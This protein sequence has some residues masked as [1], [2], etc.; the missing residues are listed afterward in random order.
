M[1]RQR[2]IEGG[3]RIILLGAGASVEAGVPSSRAMTSAILK[4]FELFGKPHLLHMLRFVLGGLLFDAGTRG[5]D[6]LTGVDV[7]ALFNAVDLLAQRQRLEV[8]PFVAAWHPAIDLLERDQRLSTSSTADLE[9][10][11]GSL[12]DTASDALT[13]ITTGAPDPR[14]V[15]AREIREVLRSGLQPVDGRAFRHL[16]DEMLAAL[17]SLCSIHDRSRVD[18][19]RPLANLAREQGV[20][21]IA[22]L[23]YDES[24]EM[25]FEDETVPL[26]TSI[27]EWS[28]AHRVV[29]PSVGGLLLKLHGSLDWVVDVDPPLPEHLPE[30]R[31]RRGT[32]QDAPTW[33]PAVVFGGRNKLRADG[34]FLSLFSAFESALERADSMCVVGYS[35]RDD[36]VNAKIRERINRDLQ[37]KMI[38]IDPA[39]SKEDVAPFARELLDRCGRRVEVKLMPASEGIELFFGDREVD[40]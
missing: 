33:A 2:N 16:A 22:T 20:A 38:V 9:R 3:R 31:I 5:D 18:Y 15:L 19:L 37:F 17:R 35:F 8:S 6:P 11:L 4:H 21:T 25:A 7:E 12:V 23:N 34:P 28:K 26:T 29:E 30:G 14:S 32:A 1:V 24:V 39:F 36:H 40:G 27:D 13:R 10:A